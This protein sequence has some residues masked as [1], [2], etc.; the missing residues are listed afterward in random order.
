MSER[1]KKTGRPVVGVWVYGY[2][3]QAVL[4]VLFLLLVL[5]NKYDCQAGTA[6]N[7]GEADYQG[8]NLSNQPFDKNKRINA[9]FFI[10]AISCLNL[11]LFQHP[12]Y[13]IRLKRVQPLK[14]RNRND[15]A[16]RLVLLVGDLTS[17]PL[18][19]GL[20]TPRHACAPRISSRRR[21]CQ[22]PPATSACP[23]RN[24]LFSG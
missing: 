23:A 4:R 7:A 13:G 16:V 2:F 12:I 10:A 24:R 6:A 9:V 8:E 22:N 14:L 15:G 3:V 18:D 17:L 11:G 5:L 19:L 21:S 1:V 20:A